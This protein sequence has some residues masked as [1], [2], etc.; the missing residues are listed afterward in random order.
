M[1]LQEL[2]DVLTKGE[3]QLKAAIA[4]QNRADRYD[5]FCGPLGCY[6]SRLIRNTDVLEDRN[7]VPFPVIMPQPSYPVRSGMF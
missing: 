4:Q 6:P 2:A 5:M 7:M 1:S 3:F